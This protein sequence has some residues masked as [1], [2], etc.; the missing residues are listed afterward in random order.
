[1]ALADDW[2]QF[3]GPLGNGVAAPT[4]IPLQ[5]S[6]KTN[7]GWKLAV[8]GSGW[9]QP[10]VVGDLVFVTSAIS[11]QPV[12]PKVYSEGVDDPHTIS[13]SSVSA[14]RMSIAWK[15]WAIDLAAGT[16]RWDTT[17]TSGPP[18]YAIHPSNT[19]ASETP[20]S[21]KEAVYAFFGTAGTVAS[22]DHRGHILWKREL[23]PFRQQE[24]YGTGSSLRLNGG[25][26]Y[27]QCFSEEKAFLVCLD[28][29]DGNEKWRVVREKPGTC[30]NTPLFW[31]TQTGTDLVIYGQNLMTGHDPSTGRELWRLDGVPM[32]SM[33]SA[34]AD[35]L[36]LYCGCRDP[37]KGGPLHALKIEAGG[38][39]HQGSPSKHSVSAAWAAP[40]GAPGMPSPVATAGHVF[41][42][43]GTILSCFNATNGVEQF[44]E[45]LP[46]FRAVIASPVSVGNH[47]ILQDESGAA[48]T[49]AA[50]PRFQILGRA[51]L[52]DVFWASPAVARNA[53]LLRGADY[54]YCVRTE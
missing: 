25:L 42:P 46:G 17:I 39:S 29:K 37:Y 51:Q 24:N 54:L 23:G 47:I 45:R 3:R 8:P 5:W 1:L 48:L 28:A 44:K 12:R 52:D 16:F 31:R 7:L 33:T 10:I 40:G 14:A 36:H 2:P 41:V 11:S 13:G 18:T 35:G 26:L 20:A 38:T 43:N 34:C 50:G 4:A 49:L 19:Y 15:V 27:I 30:W 53:L 21:D 9:S 6:S 22:L 32:P